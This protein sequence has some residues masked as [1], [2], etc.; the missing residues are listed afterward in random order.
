M[1]DTKD[2]TKETLESAAELYPGAA[3]DKADKEKVDEQLVKE[4]VKTENN[5]PRSHDLF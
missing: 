5:N 3:V 4:R 2:K 1:K